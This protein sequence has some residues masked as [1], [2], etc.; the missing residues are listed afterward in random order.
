MTLDERIF[1]WLTVAFFTWF[2]V[3]PAHAGSSGYGIDE[4]A[5]APAPSYH[6]WIFDPD[7]VPTSGRF[8][9][10]SLPPGFEYIPWRL[11]Q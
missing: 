11:G 6:P 9:G 5:A 1:W 10:S 7:A 2:S 8:S 4:A 3:F